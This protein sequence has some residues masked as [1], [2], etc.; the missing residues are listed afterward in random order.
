MKYNFFGFPNEL[1]P[2]EFNID[3][4]NDKIHLN[5]GHLFDILTFHLYID[6]KTSITGGDIPK[7]TGQFLSSIDKL[8]KFENKKAVRWCWC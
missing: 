6:G 4:R 2:V 5:T 8:I 3:R 1:L 7:M